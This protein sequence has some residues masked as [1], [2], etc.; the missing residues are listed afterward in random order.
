MAKAALA[1]EVIGDVV[2]TEEEEAGVAA[3]VT[4]RPPIKKTNRVTVLEMTRPRRD[5]YG[6]TPI[7]WTPHSHLM[8]K[9]TGWR[10]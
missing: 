9:M 8:T 1:V 6:S 4:A 7:N 2:E 10:I 5:R 3:A